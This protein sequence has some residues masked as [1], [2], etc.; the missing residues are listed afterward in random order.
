MKYVTQITDSGPLSLRDGRNTANSST[1]NYIPGSTLLGALAATHN[2]LRQDPGQFD[3]FFFSDISRFGNLYPS[4]FEHEDLKGYSDAV[5]PLP[6]TALSCKRFGGFLFDEVDA[7][8][9]PHHGVYDGLISWALFA[10]SGEARTD[11]LSDL[12]QCPIENCPAPLDTFSGF[13]RRGAFD[14]EARGKAEVRLGLRTRTGINRATGAVQRE[15]LY[16]REVLRPG[17]TFWGTVSVTDNRADEFSAFVQ[18]A[19]ASDLLRLGNNRSRGFG[20]VRLALDELPAEDDSDSLA[21]RLRQFNSRL[22][23]R[24]QEKGIETPHQLYVPITLTSD[25]ILYDNLLRCRTAL[26]P[27][28][29]AE[30]WEIPDGELIYQNSSVRRV[31]G[32]NALW[33]LPKPDELAIT[34]GSVFLF[35][36]NTPLEEASSPLLK[37]QKAGIGSRRREGFGQILIASPFHWE[38]QGQ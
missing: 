13:Y 3:D 20:R 4:A 29:L 24:A 36:L 6:R 33:R 15:I 28:Y 2:L 17:M 16:S 14:E 21:E 35:G 26:E 37:M 34:M 9:H 23:Q 22:R 32:W 18:E 1:L 7:R 8:D 12:E 5:N 19:N 31:M 38:V 25:A 11:V 27:G 10:L 30:E